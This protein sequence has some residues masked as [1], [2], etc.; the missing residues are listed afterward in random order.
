[1]RSIR[2]SLPPSGFGA[3]LNGNGGETG[4]VSRETI[5]ETSCLD[6]KPFP[7]PGLPIWLGTAFRSNRWPL[8]V[9]RVYLFR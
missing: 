7:S 6:D 4:I 5:S 9:R 1:M 3:T 2:F 8:G